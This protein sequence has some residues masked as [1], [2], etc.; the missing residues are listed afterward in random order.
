MR[1]YYRCTDCLA[2]VCIETEKRVKAE[3]GICGCEYMEFMGEVVG[4]DWQKVERV[5]HSC[6]EAC[7]TAQGPNCD[8]ACGG[9]NHGA[10]FQYSLEVVASGKVRITLD[11]DKEKRVAI[12][13]EYQDAIGSAVSRIKDKM[14]HSW[15]KY[16]SGVWMESKSIWWICKGYDLALNNALKGKQHKS[17]MSK[18]VAIAAEEQTK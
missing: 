11:T 1:L 10:G 12:A 8:C 16:Q 17:R 6:N 13:K 14:G 2:T 15:E 5:S 9:A 3:C 4:K 7:V 18:L